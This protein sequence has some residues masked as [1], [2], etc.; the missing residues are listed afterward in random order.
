MNP[1]GQMIKP[2]GYFPTGFIQK[3]SLFYS[4]RLAGRCRPGLVNKINHLYDIK[5]INDAVGID[6]NL[7]QRCRRWPGFVDII[8]YIDNVK[9]IIDIVGIRV[10]A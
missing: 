7:F 3:T 9:D 6:V 4:L 5:D 1:F 8:Y 10:A 2:A